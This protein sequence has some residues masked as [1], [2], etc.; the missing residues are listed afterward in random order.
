MIPARRQCPFPLRRPELSSGTRDSGAG[1]RDVSGE[2]GRLREAGRPWQ[3]GQ[4]GDA[5]GKPRAQAK[6]RE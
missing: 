6:N 2:Q 3:Q 5:G 4:A 1:G